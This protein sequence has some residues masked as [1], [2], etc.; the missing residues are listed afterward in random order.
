MLGLIIRRGCSTTSTT[1]I[2]EALKTINVGKNL[3]VQGW[4]KAFRHQKTISFIDLDD[5]LTQA[6]SRLQIV[7]QSELVPKHLTHHSAIQVSGKLRKSDHPGQEVELEA[8][9]IKLRSKVE[10]VESY[11]FQPRKRYPNEE[12]PRSFPHFRAKLNDFA[13]MLRIRNAATCAIHKY[14]QDNRYIQIQTPILTSND[15]EGAGEVFL[16]T[17]ANEKLNAS[18]KKP[19]NEDPSSAYFD[20]RVFLTVSGQI[21]LEAI[22]NGIERV[23]TFSPAFRAETGR[24]RRH[25]SEFSMVEAEVAFLDDMSDLLQIQGEA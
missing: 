22:C 3:K 21:H 5:G 12:Y 16:V 17:P 20:K 7:C 23:Y 24:S 10:D 2:R 1:S 14:F 15:C 8:E 11:P 25:L 9:V 18:M 4:V 19:S 13:S 6:G